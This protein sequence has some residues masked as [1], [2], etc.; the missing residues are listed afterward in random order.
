[1]L[2]SWRGRCFLS[3]LVPQAHCLAP[4]NGLHRQTFVQRVRNA[5]ADEVEGLLLNGGK[6][7]SKHDVSRLL[8]GRI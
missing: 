7:G 5:C 3:V 4:M 1:M 6:P 2:L 8:G